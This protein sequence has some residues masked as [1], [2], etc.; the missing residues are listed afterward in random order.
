[1]YTS[2]NSMQLM[3][4][5]TLMWLIQ[6]DA[7]H[8]RDEVLRHITQ[9]TTTHCNAL[10]R[11]ATHCNALQRTATHCNALQRTATH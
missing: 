9:C 3:D 11:T 6:Q 10:Q 7:L 8:V 1:M 5:R 4:E 2:A